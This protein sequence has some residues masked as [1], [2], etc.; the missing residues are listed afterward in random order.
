MPARLGATDAFVPNWV[1]A[2]DQ[3]PHKSKHKFSNKQH[4]GKLNSGLTPSILVKSPSF[5]PS[6]PSVED[7]PWRPSQ[8]KKTHLRPINKTG[9]SHLEHTH[10]NLRQ[11]LSLSRKCF[12]GPLLCW[13]G[14]VPSKRAESDKIVSVWGVICLFQ[15]VTDPWESRSVEYSLIVALGMYFTESYIDPGQ[16]GNAWWGLL[17]TDQ[18]FSAQVASGCRTTY[19][20][21]Q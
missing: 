12:L 1:S 15:N 4:K 3:I 10:T 13:Q 6:I 2:W 19:A 8:N 20:N 14:R 18:H 5:Q 11:L 9:H 7:F 16:K 17:C 21:S